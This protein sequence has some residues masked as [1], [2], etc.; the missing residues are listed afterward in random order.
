MRPSVKPAPNIVLDLVSD[1]DGP[2]KVVG[3]KTDISAPGVTFI[4]L[5]RNAGIEVRSGGV[6][7]QTASTKV[8]GGQYAGFLFFLDPA[9]KEDAASSSK[10]EGM[11]L[12]L[13]GI[14]YL[15]GQKLLISRDS[16]VTMNP[17][18]I[19]ADYLLPQSGNLTLY[20]DLTTTTASEVAMRKSTTEAALIIR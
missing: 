18:S 8:T 4:F 5:G 9:S 11:D 1:K 15:V 16:N 20:G 13:K 6:W 17:G 14:I 10:I 12:N 7:N 3:D 19:V 2:L